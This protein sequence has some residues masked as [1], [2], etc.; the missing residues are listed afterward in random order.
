MPMTSPVLRISGPS[1]W[2]TPRPSTVRNRLKGSTASFTETGASRGRLPPSPDSGQ[3]ALGAQLGDGRAEHAPGRH[4]GQR[5]A[6]GLGDE[7]AVR[8]ARGLASST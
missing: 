5:H 4:L 6:R 1:M 7:G 2:S 3:Q 8:E